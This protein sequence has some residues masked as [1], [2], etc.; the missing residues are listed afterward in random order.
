MHTCIPGLTDDCIRPQIHTHTHTHICRQSHTHTHTQTH[1]Q[2]I[3]H[4]HTHTQTHTHIQ[5][6]THTQTKPL[7]ISA[8]KQCVSALSAP[9]TIR[10]AE[11]S[12]VYEFMNLSMPVYL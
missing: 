10:H 7:F 8:L 6:R 9:K 2:A 5:T 4:T 12:H 11:T 1:M 3:I